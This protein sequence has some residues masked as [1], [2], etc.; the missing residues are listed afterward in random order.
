LGATA[1]PRANPA[2]Q[3]P[4]LAL[5]ERE[6]VAGG[7]VLFGPPLAAAAVDEAE[8]VP[9]AAGP[10]PKG[11]EC[12]EERASCVCRARF[13]VP[14][15]EWRSAFV[16]VWPA[17]G[18]CPVCWLYRCKK[19]KHGQQAPARLPRMHAHRYKHRNARLSAPGPG[20][21]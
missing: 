11:D 1:S 7:D 5:P 17:V 13:S 21:P 14:L 8:T 18:V 3:V 4:P 2:P 12:P 15:N 6:C 20:R 10:A 9:S 16:G 19:E